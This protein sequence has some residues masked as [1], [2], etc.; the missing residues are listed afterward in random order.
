[1][2]SRRHGD[3]GCFG[4]TRVAYK[5]LRSILRGMFGATGASQRLIAAAVLPDTG[6]DL[7]LTLAQ[8]APHAVRSGAVAVRSAE[9]ARPSGDAAGC[10]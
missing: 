7:L 6:R 10:S 3:R 5:P 1:M 4:V 2:S 8:V 9:A